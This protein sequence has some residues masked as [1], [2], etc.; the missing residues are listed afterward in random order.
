M[1]KCDVFFNPIPCHLNMGAVE[2]CGRTHHLGLS[3][4]P[5]VRME[6]WGCREVQMEGPMCKI[7]LRPSESAKQE[8]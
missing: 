6:W 4:V 1:G 3:F 8:E 5:V 7:C 2:L